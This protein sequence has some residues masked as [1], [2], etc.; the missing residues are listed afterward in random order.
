MP[1]K[2][3]MAA[4]LDDFAA[5]VRLDFATLDAE[6]LRRV[7]ALPG[8]RTADMDAVR[9]SERVMEVAEQAAYPSALA[10]RHRDFAPAPPHDVERRSGVKL[11]IYRPEGGGLLPVVVWFFGGG[12]V[13]GSAEDS[14]FICAA[15]ANRGRCVVVCPDYRLA[16]EHPF[17]A[18]VDDAMAALRWVAARAAEIGGDAACIT[19]AGDSA[20]GNLATV[21]AQAAAREGIGLRAQILIY[22]VLDAACDTASWREMGDGY[23]L[24]AEWM[25]WYWRQYAPD[26]GDVR[27]SPL[28]AGDVRGVAPAVIHTAEFDILRDEA[29]MY[30]TR[31]RAAGVAVMLRRWDGQVHG[32][33]RLGAVTQDA[34]ALLGEV[35]GA[36]GRDG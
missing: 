21:C 29:E 25:R 9:V 13:V 16:P 12:F 18:A 26:A 11:R 30:A 17:P 2:P 5:S 20:G 34:E 24:T 19:V 10:G 32:F 22:P 15:L 4:F 27:A 23:G 8:E 14:D 35:V 1:V 31:L 6:G 33:L 7:F 36:V 28:R 3:E